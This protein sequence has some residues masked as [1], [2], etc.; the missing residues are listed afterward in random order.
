MSERIIDKAPGKDLIKI[1]IK[2]LSFDDFYAF[3]KIRVN[4]YGYP[5]IHDRLVTYGIFDDLINQFP[6]EKKYVS[7]SID[8][9]ITIAEQETDEKF[10]NS[11]FLIVDFCG[12]AKK[13]SKPTA[14]QIERITKLCNRVKKL[15]FVPNLISF[16]NQILNYLSLEKSFR[17]EEYLVEPDD[18]NEFIDMH[19]ST[20]DNNTY[21]SCPVNEAIIRK[22]IKGIVGVYEPLKF[23]RSAKIGTDRYWVWLYKNITGNIWSWYITVK[24]DEKN[25]VVVEKHSMHSGVT[26]TPERLLLEYHYRI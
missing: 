18:Y 22:E 7:M 25:E 16:W 2:K 12:I 26:K 15:S 3:Y 11:I 6:K 13:V 21:D 1:I 20:I 17:N 19:F 9:S 23:V 8:F 4:R 24:Q 14:L 5:L 10:L